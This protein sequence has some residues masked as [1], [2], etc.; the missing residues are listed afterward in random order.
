MEDCAMLDL[1]M[2][3]IH[4]ILSLISEPASLARLASTCN[5]WRNL[6]M[7]RAFLDDLMRRRY[8]HGF[9]PCLLL[10]FF[11]Q[12]STGTESPPGLR[13]HK[14]NKWNHLTP[15]FMPVSELSQSIGLGAR[16]PLTLGTFMRGCGSR[17]NF[18]EPVASQDGFLALR[19]HPEGINV[20]GQRD[21]LCVCNPLTGEI[22]DIPSIPVASPDKYVLLV[23]EDTIFDGWTSQSFQLVAIWIREGRFTIG[24]YCSKIKRWTWWEH[25]HELMPG[26]YVVRSP[27]AASR[28]AIHFLCGSSINW[29]LTHVATLNVATHDL[30]YLELPSDAK[31]SKAPLLANSADGALLLLLLKGREMSLWKHDVKHG[32]DTSSWV[33][34]ETIDL[35]S[36]LPRRVVQ[37]QA[38]AK[39]KLEM[40]LGKSG[41]VLLWVEGGGLFLFSLSDKLMRKIN[42]ERATKKYC[43]CPYEIDW[44]SCLTITNLIIDGAILRDTGRKKIQHRWRKL[45]ARHMKKNRNHL[46]GKA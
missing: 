15:S 26:L 1:P 5:F 2:D 16:R 31:R 3:I 23:T 6:I 37:M 30:S 4:K 7:D 19:R 33:L 24:S 22:F 45:I 17:L 13:H 20:Q 41:A 28:G 8:G 21:N 9:S 36:S 35:A 43:F 14:Q 32:S 12:V 10:G 42:N 44:L 34:S 39:I 27:A 18:Y 38:R 25:T 46:K 40:F 11:F 29:T